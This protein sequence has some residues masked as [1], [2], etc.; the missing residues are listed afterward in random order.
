MSKRDYYDVLE[1]SKTASDDEIKKAYRKK[2]LKFHPDKNPGDSEAEE[3]FKEAAEAYEVLRDPNKRSRYDQFGHAGVGG[4]AAGGG[5]GGG[6]MSMDDIFSNFGDIF[7]SAFGGGFGFGGGGHSRSSGRR[8]VRRG[9]NLRVKVKLSL[10]EIAH[11]T[12]KKIKVNKYVACE[13]CNG[14]GAKNG[15]AYSTC[16][17][18][19]GTGQV[20]QVTNTILGQMQTSST[21][22]ACGGEGQIITDKCPACYGEGIVKGEEVIEIQIPA[23]V[24]SGMQ[25]SM[26]GKGNAAPRGGVNGDLI[27]LIE[28]VP[29]ESLERD[30][31]NLLYEHYVSFPEAVMGASVEIPTVDGKARIKIAPGTQPGKVLR[32]KGKGLPDVNGY[33]QGDLL[34]NINV[35]VPKTLSKEE[36]AF[37]ENAMH[38]P[39]FKPNPGSREKSFFHKMR[40]Y[41]SGS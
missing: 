14:T 38:S 12:T 7:G 8:R 2:A 4:G 36:T 21:C 9:S 5:F 29:H 17:T 34:V 13:S 27:V 20:T 37:L 31:I 16:Q 24:T 3:K 39:N 18:C 28:E 25:L 6:G 22:P 30:G 26:T 10:K 19:H 40:D 23:G 41:F 33:G 1:V 11:G 32:L 15:G 35:W